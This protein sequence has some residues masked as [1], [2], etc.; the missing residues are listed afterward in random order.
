MPSAAD[1]HGRLLAFLYLCPVGII[2]A[3]GSGEIL[4]I[5]AHASRILMPLAHGTGLTSL[6]EVLAPWTDEV[7]ILMQGFLHERGVV[8]TSQR[9]RLH[10][11]EEAE[12]RRTFLSFTIHKLE[13]ERF[14]VKVRTWPAQYKGLDD[15]LAAQ[16]QTR[17][18]AA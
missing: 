2:E 3:T 7:A 10:G 12:G 9:V 6:F 1:E 14:R 15:Y 5:N 18:V 11:R 4:L 13:R 8:C 16:I 17:E